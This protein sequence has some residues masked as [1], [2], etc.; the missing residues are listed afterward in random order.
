MNDDE[1]NAS[2]HRAVE[3]PYLASDAAL[4][5]A[6]SAMYQPRLLQ[7]KGRIGRLR[8]LA[9]LSVVCLLTALGMMILG[10]V[11]GA[12]GMNLSAAHSDN[13]MFVFMALMYVPLLVFSFVLARRRFNDAGH[14]GWF[15]VLLLVP[16]VNLFVSL[17]LVFAQGS[18]GANDYGLPPAPNTLWI[19]IVGAVLPLLFVIGMVASIAI[20]A[21]VAVKNAG[22]GSSGF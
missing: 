7:W 14:S 16:F 2:G 6:T 3:N 11:L 8:Y 21:Y 4:S 1:P 10:A 15:S 20:P 5:G 18:E 9:Y 19:K 22:G 17:Y 13:L 12:M